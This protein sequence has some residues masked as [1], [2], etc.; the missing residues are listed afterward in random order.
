MPRPLGIG[1]PPSSLVSPERGQA[2]E[3]SGGHAVNERFAVNID[4]AEIAYPPGFALASG[5][6]ASQD[7]PYRPVDVDDGTFACLVV[8]DTSAKPFPGHGPH[9]IKEQP[10][11]YPGDNQGKALI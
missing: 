11:R 1:I 9:L 10:H 7:R 3:I 2:R 4:A 8:A 5:W 6:P